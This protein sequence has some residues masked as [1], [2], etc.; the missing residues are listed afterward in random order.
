MAV[1]CKEDKSEKSLQYRILLCCTPLSK[2]RFDEWDTPVSFTSEQGWKQ[3]LQ[4]DL[5]ISFPP[6]NELFH[7]SVCGGF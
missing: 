6:C 1:K 5:W 7:R 2:D 4:P 3:G